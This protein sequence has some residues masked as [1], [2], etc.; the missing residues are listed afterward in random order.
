MPS[1]ASLKE[2]NIEVPKEK[3]VR[4][5]PRKTIEKEQNQE[6]PKEKKSRK[7]TRKT[8]EKEI[9]KP[10]KI[11]EEETTEKTSGKKKKRCSSGALLSIIQYFNNI[12]KDCEKKMG[13]GGLLKMKL[14]EVL[15]ALSCFI[16][17]KFDST[18]KNDK[19]YEEWT[20]LFE[21]KTMI[22]PQV[23]KMNII[24]SNKADMNFKMNFIALLI[25]SLIE[26]TSSGKANTH[27]LNYITKKKK[28]NKIDWCS[29]LIECLVK[30]KQSFDPSSATNN[31][32][33]PSAYLV[34]LYV[35]S[36]KSELI[37]LERK[38]P[39]IYHWSTEKMKMRENYKKEELGDFGTGES[40][41]EF[42]EEKLNEYDYIEMIMKKFKKLKMLTDNGVDKFPENENGSDD[43]DDDDDNDDDGEDDDDD[44]DDDDEGGGEENEEEK[45]NEGG[46]DNEGGGFGEN[47]DEG[48]IGE[49][50]FAGEEDEVGSEEDDVAGKYK[51]GDNDKGGDGKNQDGKNVETG[52]AKSREQPQNVEGGGVERK[53]LEGT[54][55]YKEKGKTIYV[56]C[57]GGVDEPLNREEKSQWKTLLYLL[58]SAYQNGKSPVKLDANL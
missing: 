17:Q 52:E 2:Q 32:N 8:V 1:K 23:I 27:P 37:K 25:N 45:N 50:N 4:K 40:N 9:T 51:S 54:N 31:F 35:D 3:Q 57:F 10:K 6:V 48:D 28:I 36:V 11:T 56:Q 39:V 30:T 29:Y 14:I 46:Q 5:S 38:H 16:L 21:N 24:S 13:F 33:G 7:S 18:T 15:R 49:E 55:A 20:N 34:L 19:T 26:S 58:T 43:D 47:V 22:R 41:E 53:N 44:D 42:I 12:H